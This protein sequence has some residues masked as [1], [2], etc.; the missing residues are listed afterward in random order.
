MNAVLPS[1]SLP[2]PSRKVGSALGLLAVMIVGL[3][4]AFPSHAL[5][6]VAFTGI[7][8]PLVSALTQLAALGPSVK[9]LVAFIER[10]YLCDERGAWY[11]QNGPQKVFVALAYAP[12]IVRLHQRAFCTTSRQPFTLQA[13]YADDNGN[14]VLSGTV[15]GVDGTQAALLHDHDLETFSGSSTWHGEACGTELGLFHH[16]GRDLPIEP[17]AES[18][19]PKRFSE[20]IETFGHATF[21]VGGWFAGLPYGWCAYA[22]KRSFGRTFD[23]SSAKRAG[24]CD[25]EVLTL[26]AEVS[27]SATCAVGDPSLKPV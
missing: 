8:G 16:D 25:G 20:L 10:N 3:M 4:A 11:F 19:V 18:E 27:P 13:C 21:F 5:D 1:V 23:R 6:L 14:V 2:M 9:A 24:A 22:S 7:T 26:R 15:D 12:W 17:I